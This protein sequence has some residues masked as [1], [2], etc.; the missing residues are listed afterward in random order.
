M[1]HPISQKVISLVKNEEADPKTLTIKTISSHW[2]V[3][4]L[5]TL[6]KMIEN[7]EP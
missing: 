1:R 5:D 6:Q 3:F 4:E 7:T 2:K